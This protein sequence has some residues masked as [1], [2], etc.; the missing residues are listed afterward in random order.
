MRFLVGFL[1]AIL[2]LIKA[3]WAGESGLLTG[4]YEYRTDKESL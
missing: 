3:C 4:R 1:A 2:L